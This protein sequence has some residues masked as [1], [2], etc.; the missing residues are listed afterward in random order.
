MAGNRV[1]QDCLNV[2]EVILENK[3]NIK[4]PTI[5]QPKAYSPHALKWNIEWKSIYWLIYIIILLV[6]YR[7]GRVVVFLPPGLLPKCMWWGYNFPSGHRIL[8][9]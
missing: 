8:G 7:L 1:R 9:L 3:G 6:S 4:Q 5:T 2:I